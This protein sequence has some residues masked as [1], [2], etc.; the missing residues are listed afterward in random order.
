MEYKLHLA[1]CIGEIP[2][3][4]LEEGVLVE[5]TKPCPWSSRIK[6]FPELPT[7]T[8]ITTLIEMDHEEWHIALN[9]L[10]HVMTPVTTT[11]ELYEGATDGDVS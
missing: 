11:T 7:P 2:E 4:R 5:G 3:W 8:S 1:T 6:D 10:G 9:I